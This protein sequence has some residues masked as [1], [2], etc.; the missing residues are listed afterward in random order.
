M[1]DLQIFVSCQFTGIKTES[2]ISTLTTVEIVTSLHLAMCVG[3]F[4]N[5][6]YYGFNPQMRLS[7]IV[8]E[9]FDQ[10]MIE[11]DANGNEVPTVDE[12]VIDYEL[13]IR[14]QKF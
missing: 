8:R 2:T 6:M 3:V 11:L 10:G 7:F 13:N 14:P 12:D 5:E 4:N 9:D 1:I